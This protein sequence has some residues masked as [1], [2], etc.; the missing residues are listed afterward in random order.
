MDVNI[1]Y[2]FQIDVGSGKE[3]RKYWKDRVNEFERNIKQGVLCRT[4][5]AYFPIAQIFSPKIILSV[6]LSWTFKFIVQQQ[7]VI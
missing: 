4:R 5:T 3:T 1:P 6:V 7:N 2:K